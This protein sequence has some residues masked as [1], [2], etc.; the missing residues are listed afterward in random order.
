[1][2][3]EFDPRHQA[4]R[5]SL[6]RLGPLVVGVGVVFAVIGFVSFFTAFG[7]SGPPRYFWC[8]FVG[9]PLIG[10][11]LGMTRFGYLGAISRY[12]ANETTPVGVDVVNTVAEGTKDAVRGVATAVGEGL[13]AGR[14]GGTVEVVRCHKCNET[15]DQDARFCK[16]C[17]ASLAKSKPCPSCLE[18]N[19]PDARF[20]DRCGKPMS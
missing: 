13:A 19:D 17:G 20:C 11:G 6:R 16:Q 5:A 10:L 9:L 18:L 8:A 12:V 2:S 15:N 4:R 7:G 1:M 14:G 3:E